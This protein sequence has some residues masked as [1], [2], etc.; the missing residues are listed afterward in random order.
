MQNPIFRKV[1][2]ERLSS[3]EQLDQI[4]VVT[5]PRTWA[6]LL[7][8]LLMLGSLLVWAYKGSIP[9]TST[10]Q[11][12]LVRHGGVLNVVALGSGVVTDLNIK[13]GDRL[14]AQQIVAHIAQPA[15]AERI[16]AAQSRLDQARRERER[17]LAAR[18]SGMRLQLDALHR[19]RENAERDIKVL[20]GRS[21]LVAEQLPDEE[22]LLAKGL[23]TRHQL[24][25]TQ[26]KIVDIQ[27]QI[28]V[29]RAQLKQYDAQQFSLESQPVESDQQ[30]RGLEDDLKL[31]LSGLQQELSAASNVITPFSGE[32]L[33]VKVLP[34]GT[35][36]AGTAVLSIQPTANDLEAIVYLG[37]REAKRVQPGMDAQISP[38]TVR[39][40]EYGFLRAKV[41]SVASYPSTPEALMRN[42]QNDTLVQALLH[43][44]PVTELRVSLSPDPR[45]EGDY[46][47]SS[48]KRPPVSLS[49]GTMCVAQIV[50]E[51]QRPISLVVPW[52]R[53]TLG[54]N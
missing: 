9:T 33:E 28:A 52:F 6:A 14:R 11:G 53:E 24:V 44:G 36:V 10:G 17:G 16:R 47:W 3:P 18:T 1:A 29:L 32:V 20:E 42:F 7:G 31:T 48:S 54:V 30:M 45:A 21:A 12:V 50:T 8:V 23:I 15:T 2:L 4:M 37:S 41:V 43:A 22:Q 46:H 51:E 27:G 5:S 49:S 40:E 38:S 39:R 25:Q 19:Q 35:V 26:E 13:P 34:G